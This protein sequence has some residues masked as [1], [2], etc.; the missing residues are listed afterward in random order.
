MYG[1]SPHVYEMLIRRSH[2]YNGN[3]LLVR[4]YFY[5]DSP[6][7]PFAKIPHVDLFTDQTDILLK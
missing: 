5:T 4:E 1:V 6:P 7:D 2:L 3:I